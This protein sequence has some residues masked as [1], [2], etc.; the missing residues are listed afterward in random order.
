M[1]IGPLLIATIP[2]TIAVYMFV[3]HKA[4]RARA[5]LAAIALFFIIAGVPALLAAVGHPVA[6][7]WTLIGLVAGWI[8]CVLFV[9]HDIIKGEHKHQLVGRKAI[10]GG[11]GSGGASPAGGKGG[12]H[13]ARVLVAATGLVALTMVGVI[14]RSVIASEI[15]SGFGQAGHSVLHQRTS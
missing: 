11:S 3:R 15:G 7:G 5:V 2:G 8:L 13:H 1:L 6:A 14:N 12:Q 4:P 9:Y 10:G